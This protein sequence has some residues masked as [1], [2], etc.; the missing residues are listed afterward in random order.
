MTDYFE[1]IALHPELYVNSDDENTITI[2]TAPDDIR[3]VEKVTGQKT[4]IMYRDKYIILLKDAV[5]FPDN[6]LGTY[7]RIIPANK[8]NGTVIFPVI[9][10]K[11]M[12]INCY[13]HALRRF[14]WELPRGFAEDDLDAI[15]NA[16]KELYEECGLKALDCEVLGKISPDSSLLSEDV[17]VIKALISENDVDCIKSYDGSEAIKEYKIASLEEISSMISRGLI[18]DSFTISAIYLAITK[19]FLI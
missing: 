1:F 19:N 13:R 7:I 4:G 18:T 10:G 9:N 5:V 12:L 17:W 11:I 3:H 14:C 8:K 6:S 16:K 2:L 15:E